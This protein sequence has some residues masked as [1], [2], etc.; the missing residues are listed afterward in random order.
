MNEAIDLARQGIAQAEALLRRVNRQQSVPDGVDFK[1]LAQSVDALAVAL[2]ELTAAVA[3]QERELT[4]QRASVA[5][6]E[7]SR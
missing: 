4:R 7:R 6:L 3:A 5:R 1:Y 2:K